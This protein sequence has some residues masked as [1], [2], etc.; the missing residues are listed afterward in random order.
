MWALRRPGV[1]II[2]KGK[3]WKK[4]MR[5]MAFLLIG[6]VMVVSSAGYI[7]TL[8]T[9]PINPPE[10][11]RDVYEFVATLPKD[12][13]FAGEPEVM[14]GIPAFSRRSVL[15]RGLFPK[16]P[17][18]QSFDA[19][20]AESPGT[21]LSFCERYGVDYLVIDSKV[22]SPEYLASRAIRFCLARRG[23]DICQRFALCDQV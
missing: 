8:E 4:G 19:Q 6:T 18:V 20:Y 21:V 9:E 7:R 13:M 1:R 10:A 15:I 11:A 3:L 2:G 12:A 5:V 22:F 17:V 14:T 23:T 16:G